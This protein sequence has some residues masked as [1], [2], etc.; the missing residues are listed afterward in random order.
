MRYLAN[1]I[2]KTVE[3][4]RQP[5]LQTLCVKRLRI[6]ILMRGHVFHKK[7]IAEYGV[8]LL[9]DLPPQAIL[10]ILMRCAAENALEMAA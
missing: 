4:M 2:T 1:R 3:K 10:E 6:E 5:S 9:Q 8:D 7:L